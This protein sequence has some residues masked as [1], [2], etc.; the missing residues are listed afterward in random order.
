MTSHEKG[1]KSLSESRI[2]QYDKKV[3]S[4]LGHRPVI[5]AQRW[6][7]VCVFCIASQLQTCT[8]STIQAVFS[9][10]ALG[11]DATSR[12]RPSRAAPIT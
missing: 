3:V 1:V 12:H 5:P 2:T 9:V 10:I 6:D 8:L 11:R 7:N 4:M